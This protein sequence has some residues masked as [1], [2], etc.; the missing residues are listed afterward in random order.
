MAKRKD[1]ALRKERLFWQRHD[2][3]EVF[4]ETGW[5]VAEKGAT[6][7]QSVYLAVA[8]KGGVTL[9]LSPKV[10]QR[11][12]IRKGEQVQA[13]IEGKRLII[14]SAKQSQNRTKSQRHER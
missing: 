3:M 8:G 9:R 7:V 14:T 12:G 5:E 6:E 11:L 2:A 13:W 10:L 1:A 4:G